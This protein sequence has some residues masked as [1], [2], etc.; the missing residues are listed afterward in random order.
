METDRDARPPE[1]TMLSATKAPS[2]ECRALAE[3]AAG[4]SPIRA[5][6]SLTPQERGNLERLAFEYGT[7]ADS[8][9][10]VE[11]DGDC[12]MLPDQSAAVAIVRNQCRKHLHMPGGLLAADEDKPRLLEVLRG[13]VGR[14][15][16]TINCYSLT[17]ADLPLFE[18]YGFQINKFG[19]EP[20]LD[21]GDLTWSGKPYE[22]IR[23][24]VNYC[25]RHGV[26]CVEVLPHE[27]TGEH[28]ER[29]KLELFDIVREDLRDR[30]YPHEL[31]LLEGR[32]FPDHLGRRRLFVARR[33]GLEGIEAFLI[34]NPMRGGREWAFESYRRRKDATRGVMAFMMKS[35]ID[36]LQEEG[37]EQVDFCVV[38]GKGMMDRRHHPTE[39]RKIRYGMHLW[40][41]H[42]DMFMNF[43]GQE[44]FKSRFRPRMINRYVC[45]S[46]R[47][48]VSSIISFFRTA[49]AF[50]PNYRNVA[51]AFWQHLRQPPPHRIN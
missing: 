20:V 2:T 40:Y 1:S 6:A 24:Q 3:P 42:F 34:C 44:Y 43:R 30:P 47:V 13:L 9:L 39:S 31:A 28:W 5:R 49:G 35:I 17:D 48:T 46:P 14:E 33:E 36:R 11:P 27:R 25:E 22:W 26:A 50:S 41:R 8:Y 29:L 37:V 21:L 32:L 10:A 23:R 38:P 18:R 16:R 51:R 45:V 19:E 12:L 15:G 4:G 7:A